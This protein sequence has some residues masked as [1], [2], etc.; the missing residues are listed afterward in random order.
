M[1]IVISCFVDGD[2][3][4]S[5]EQIARSIS[6]QVRQRGE[7]VSN[8][9]TN[10]SAIV[11]SGTRSGRSYKIP[12]TGRY[13]TASAPGEPPAV[14]TGAYRASFHPKT[15]VEG[16]PGNDCVIHS[17]TESLH[18]VGGYR[19]YELMENGS[20]GGK[21]APR[22]HAEKIVAL[23]LPMAYRIYQNPYYMT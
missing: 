18:T 20:P 17:E 1:A 14:R 15:S 4:Q 11:L 16:G 23:A 19:L 7:V 12:G 22:P 3:A 21:I 8:E 6:M 10:V 2:V 13:Y 5:I 9:L